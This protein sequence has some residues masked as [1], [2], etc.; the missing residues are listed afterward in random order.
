MTGQPSRNFDT[1]EWSMVFGQTLDHIHTGWEVGPRLLEVPEPSEVAGAI[2]EAIA[3]AIDEQ[4]EPRAV[5]VEIS[6][7]N[8]GQWPDSG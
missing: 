7:D 4:V 3:N 8:R 6:V 5:E 2:L 1:L